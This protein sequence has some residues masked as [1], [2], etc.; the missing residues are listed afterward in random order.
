MVLFVGWLAWLVYSHSNHASPYADVVFIEDYPGATSRYAT[1]TPVLRS[2]ASVVVGPAAGADFGR[3]HFKDLDGDGVKETI[4]ETTILIDTG[5]FYS[6]T[7]EVLRYVPG[8][9]GGQ[10]R[11]ERVSFEKR[12]VAS[13][14]R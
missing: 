8:G 5:E 12:G 7:R 14:A 2:D 4:V 13:W 3:I 6:D 10:P 11:M 9:D 1:F